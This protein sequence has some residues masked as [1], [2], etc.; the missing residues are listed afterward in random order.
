MIMREKIHIN[1]LMMFGYGQIKRHKKLWGEKKQKQQ[2]QQQMHT[3]L[4]ISGYGELKA[5]RKYICIERERERRR[6]N[7][8]ATDK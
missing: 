1:M 8:V 2:K 4:K 7:C 3:L 6:N 5:R